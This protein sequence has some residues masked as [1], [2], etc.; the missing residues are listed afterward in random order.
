MTGSL[1]AVL[2]ASLLGSLH[3]VAMCGPLAALHLAPT[4]RATLRLGVVHALGRAATYVALGVGA[5]AAGRALDLAG[6]LASVQRAAAIVAGLAILIWGLVAI[7][8]VWWPRE[9]ASRGGA[10]FSAGLVRLGARRPTTR[11]AM[12]GVLTGLL[13][14]GWLWAFVVVAAGSASPL[15]GAAVMATFWLGTVPAMLGVTTIAAPLLRRLRARLPV[16]TALVLVALG[17]VTL[18][19]RWTNAGTAGVAQPTCHSGGAM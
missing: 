3:C 14:C 19:G 6:D 9:R 1:V 8:R 4:S 12:L 13:P 17:V 2:G 10:M 15:G 7:A 18:A 11:A 16:A 5:G